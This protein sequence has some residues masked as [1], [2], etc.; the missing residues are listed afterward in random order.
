M[1][2]QSTTSNRANADAR[3]G[4][5]V[6]GVVDGDV[7][8]QEDARGVGDPPA[9][10][11]LVRS[12]SGDVAALVSEIGLD[13]PVG[14]PEDLYAHQVLLDAVAVD[15]PVLPLRFGA[16]VGSR[17]AVVSE[18]LDENEREFA[19]ALRELDCELQYVVRA[20]YREDAVLREVLRDNPTAAS[21]REKVRAEPAEVAGDLQ[22]RLGEIINNEIEARRSQDTQ[23][24]AD[25]LSPVTVGSSVRPPTNELDA[26]HLAV[27]VKTDR[28]AD[29]EEILHGVAQEWSD[30]ATVRLLGP[31]APYDFVVAADEPRS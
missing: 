21:L 7:E 17:D 27:L 3:H 13:R 8:L 20:R 10:V 12:G 19:S 22:L 28:T 18:L 5:Y 24:L 1:A 9:P 26:A 30:R 2:A 15:A 4:W 6:Y 16:V 31:M 25:L 11:E 29:L 14:R 23:R